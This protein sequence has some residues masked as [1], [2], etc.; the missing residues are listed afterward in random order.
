MRTD[1]FLPALGNRNLSARE[2]VPW[3]EIKKQNTNFKTKH[4]K[5][6]Q[7]NYLFAFSIIKLKR[8]FT[9]PLNFLIHRVVERLIRFDFFIQVQEVPRN[10]SEER[11]VFVGPIL[12]ISSSQEVEL[13]EPASISI[14]IPLEQ[15]QI[16]LQN[17]SSTHARIFYCDTKE[18]SQEWV[19][20]TRQLKTPAKLEKG[21]V[22][23]HVNH[24]SK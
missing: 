5:L 1:F 13:T 12:H 23:F 6:N 22:T 11:K 10:Y 17:L 2:Q 4:D 19:E 15:D 9:L 3:P 20:I 21:V 18:K 24:F 7:S 16:Q 8:F 14:P